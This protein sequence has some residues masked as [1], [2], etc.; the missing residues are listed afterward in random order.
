MKLPREEWPVWREFKTQ[1][2][3][4]EV[5]KTIKTPASKICHLKVSSKSVCSCKTCSL[6]SKPCDCSASGKALKP[7]DS[8]YFQSLCHI[9]TRTNKIEKSH[10]IMARVLRTSN[11]I[12]EGKRPGGY[13]DYS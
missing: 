12:M 5:V 2:P 11:S 7:T 4:E 9:M 1:I 3:E 10:G 6:L 8:S 13:Q